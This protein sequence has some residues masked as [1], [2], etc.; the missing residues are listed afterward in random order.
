MIE[1]L[2]LISEYDDDLSSALEHEAAWKSRE[3][4]LLTQSRPRQRNSDENYTD[5]DMNS[6]GSEATIIKHIGE[7]NESDEVLRPRK[8]QKP[9]KTKK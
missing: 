6:V 4:D 1:N 2:D 5:P 3:A 8:P 7:D 9:K